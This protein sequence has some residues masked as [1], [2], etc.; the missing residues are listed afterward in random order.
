MNKRSILIFLWSLTTVAW[1]SKTS[2][3]P[4]TSSSIEQLSAVA[5]VKLQGQNSKDESANHK[6]QTSKFKLQRLESANHKVQSSNLKVQRTESSL[7]PF[8]ATTIVGGQFAEGTRWYTL[9]FKN[10][11]LA[12]AAADGTIS[13]V[14]AMAGRADRTMPT[15]P[16]N[17]LWCFVGNAAEGYILYNKAL[18]TSKALVATMPA[19]NAAEPRMETLEGNQKCAKW[20]FASSTNLTSSFT[21]PVYMQLKNADG[22]A[23]NLSGQSGQI[24][25][26]TGGK[27]NG[28]TVLIEPAYSTVLNPC[29]L[30]P[31]NATFYR[32]DKKTKGQTW[33][34]YLISNDTEPVVTLANADGKNNIGFSS[35]TTPKTIIVSSKNSQN[36]TLSVEKGYI[37]TGYS[38]TFKG[39]SGKTT[40]KD[41][42]TSKTET[43]DAVAVKTFSVTGL[44]YQSVPFQ[45]LTDVAYIQHLMVNI[46]PASVEILKQQIA[47]N[48]KY[49]TAIVFDNTKS[50]YGYRIPALGQDSNGKLYVAVD[51]RRT[52]ADIGMGNGH[53]DLVMKT[54]TDNGTTWSENS[55]TIVSGDKTQDHSSKLWTYSFGDPS[56]VVDRNNP[57]N[58]LV[59]CV[60]GHTS[61]FAS[62]Y[63]EPQHVVRLHS[64]DGGQTWTKDSLTYQ[65]YNLTKHSV[66][67]QTFGLF[68]TSGK[69]MQSRYIKHGVYNRLYIAYPTNNTKQNATFV[70][71]SDDFGATW[72]LLGGDMQL[73]SS[74]A[75]ESKVEE[76]PD[77]S[78]LVS[79]RNRSSNTRGYSLFT[80]TNIAKGEGKWE[81]QTNAIAMNN[82]VNAVNGEILI[83]PARSKADGKKL[84]VALQSITLSKS[85]ENV[86]VYFKELT[87]YNSYAT[88]EALAAD[89][90]RGMQVSLVGSCY[91]G[92]ELL[93]NGKIGYIYEE[94]AP[95]GIGGYNIMF[96]Q[97]SL[98]DLTNGKYELDRTA[99]RTPYV[100]QAAEALR[101][102]VQTYKTA[103]GKYIGMVKPEG[104]S[105]V[106]S[107]LDGAEAAVRT[108]EATP[109]VVTVYVAQEKLAN[110]YNVLFNGVER[111][112]IENGKWYRLKNKLKTNVMLSS[113]GSIL[114]PASVDE[115]TIDSALLF[116]F[117]SNSEGRWTLKNA[118]NK[119]FVKATPVQNTS[120]SVTTNQADAGKYNV[121]SSI[122]G[123][124]YLQSMNPARDVYPAI[125]ADNNGK[126]VAWEITSEASQWFIEPVN[127]SDELNSIVAL[128][129]AIKAT[130]NVY[131]LNGQCISNHSQQ[132]GGVY[133]VDGKKVIKK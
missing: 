117:S 102:R 13:E 4:T 93:N 77:G 84:F 6:V 9:K 50:P 66:A 129:P 106:E 62:R 52:G 91:T 70:I 127:Y 87:D 30:D 78:V 19:T 57:Q 49:Q 103:N 2:S 23:L 34:T 98:E 51:L 119:V 115:H 61:F 107:A 85:R 114:K 116:Q 109:S 92:M 108:A 42:T 65:I 22:Y 131:N 111:V 86:G 26:W 20:W 36:Y 56:I 88:A 96:K 35:T 18:G 63:E 44:T 32:N 126:I 39:G 29:T 132:K 12:A 76:L 60:G 72:K 122:E 64:T 133:I 25:F 120:L 40:V 45:V 75:D 16:D 48:V 27:D 100:K 79:V 125:H 59:M 24:C 110:A 8:V 31:D 21:D 83:V 104:L 89:W 15:Q 128:I 14:A 10:T 99:D 71:Y 58:V 28:S 46:A 1:A 130:Q 80:Y 43:T 95:G 121:V 113:D 73:P 38:F 54:S 69:I 124:S 118:K 82:A 33:N 5:K 37:I 94:D 47:D 123:L 3:L 7:H 53:N 81:F 105:A 17:Q 97:I 74:G 11:T 67:G 55:T 101:R 90:Q 41:V 112:K 68:L